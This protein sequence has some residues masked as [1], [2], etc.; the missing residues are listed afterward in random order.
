MKDGVIGLLIAA[1]IIW[2][3]VY[4][5]NRW[6]QPKCREWERRERER[7]RGA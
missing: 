5:D 2:A 4:A 1:P 3:I 7:G 6:W